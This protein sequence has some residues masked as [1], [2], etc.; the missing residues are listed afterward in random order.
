V[1]KIDMMQMGEGEIDRMSVE[2]IQ[3]KLGRCKGF[4]MILAE[5]AE[6]DSRIRS[7]AIEA[8]RSY[9]EKVGGQEKEIIEKT[10]MEIEIV[11]FLSYLKG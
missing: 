4:A 11:E 10:L 5:K 7:K 6:K 8:M 1:G 9:L 3:E 2:Q